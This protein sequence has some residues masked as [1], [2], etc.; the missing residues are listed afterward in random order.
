MLRATERLITRNYIGWHCLSVCSRK[1][2]SA[3]VCYSMLFTFCTRHVRPKTS[4][5]NSSSGLTEHCYADHACILITFTAC[6]VQLS[7]VPFGFSEILHRTVS[8]AFLVSIQSC[9]SSSWVSRITAALVFHLAPI[10]PLSWQLHC[11]LLRWEN[12]CL[13]V[14]GTCRLYLFGSVTVWRLFSTI[15]GQKVSKS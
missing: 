4:S 2:A 7:I 1:W 13:W 14:S 3:P 9:G 5:S 10:L 12:V 6:S 8:E 15:H 11:I